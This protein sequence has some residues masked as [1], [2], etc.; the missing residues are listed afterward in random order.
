MCTSQRNGTN[1]K[2]GLAQDA[3]WRELPANRRK[4]YSSSPTCPTEEVFCA[5]DRNRVEGV[6]YG[7]KPYVYTDSSSRAGT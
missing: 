1:L 6:V 5:P 2:V 3:T 7:T 4:A